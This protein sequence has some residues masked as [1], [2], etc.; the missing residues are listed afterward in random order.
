[1]PQLEG[2]G[3]HHKVSSRVQ[4]VV[5]IYGV[6]DMTTLM[7]R[8]ALPVIKFLD[9]K[10]YDE[11]PDLYLRASPKHYLTKD[12]PPTLILHGTIDD[13]VPIAQSDLLAARLKELG[14]PFLYDRLEGWPHVMDLA[15]SVNERCQF[16]MN[17]F[18]AQHL[19]LPK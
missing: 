8:Q 16:F 2:A 14:V 4:A 7:A 12:D 18:F 13:V 15:E 6:Y 10:T 1:V 17:E 19:P 11:A 9:N 3:G 5:D